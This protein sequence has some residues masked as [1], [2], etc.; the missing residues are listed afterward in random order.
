MDQSL[1]ESPTPLEKEHKKITFSPLLSLNTLL[2]SELS[3]K[4]G[5]D[6]PTNKG[7]RVNG[8]SLRFGKLTFRIDTDA[9]R[10]IRKL[11]RSGSETGTVS[12]V[13]GTLAERRGQ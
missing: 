3:M 8:T 2:K 13:E 11:V 9:G 5:S 7:I 1:Q 10:L 6:R 12:R 4:C